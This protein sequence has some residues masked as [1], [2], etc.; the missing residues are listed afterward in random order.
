MTPRFREPY[1]LFRP[2]RLLKR[3][4]LPI[5]LT[6]TVSQTQI[7]PTG[8]GNV[9]GKVTDN[10]T[11][12]ALGD[13]SI[14]ISGG[15]QNATSGVDGL[16]TL[17]D[18]I[19]GIHTISATRSSYRDYSSSVT[20]TANTTVTHN[21]AMTPMEIPPPEPGKGHV[22][23]IVN[24][25]D[26][27]ALSGVACAIVEKGKGTITA[28]TDSM[29]KYTLRNVTPGVQRVNMTKTGYS[30]ANVDTT[31]VEGQTVTAETVTMRKEIASGTTLLCS[32]PRTKEDAAKW[33]NEPTVSDDGGLVA[34][35][36][37]QPL[38]ATH[39]TN[40]IHTYLFQTS[41][42]TVTMLDRA[43]D[44]LEGNDDCPGSFICGNGSRVAFASD[45]TN[46]LGQGM[47]ANGWGDIFLY[48]VSSGK[49]TRIS[50]DIENKKIGGD[51]TS[52]MPSMSRDG[53]YVAFSSDA[54]N[55]CMPGLYTNPG[56]PDTINVYRAAVGPDGTTSST[57]MIS[58]RL[59]GGECDLNDWGGVIP[60]RSMQ[61]YISSDGRFVVYTSNAQKGIWWAAQGHGPADDDKTL[62][63]F[64]AQRDTPGIGSDIFLCDT[65]KT[66]GT[67]TR[68]VSIDKNNKTQPNIVG[69]GLP[70][71]WPSVSDDGSLVAFECMDQGNTWIANSDNFFDV[72]VKNVNTGELK[73]ITTAN[74]GVRGD[75]NSSKI[76]RD[77]TLCVFDSQSTGFVEHD[78][79]N[80]LDIFVYN[81]TTGEYTRVNLGSNGQQAEDTVTGGGTGSE[82]PFLS[83]NNNFVVFESDAKNLASSPYF[84]TGATDVFL[85]KWQ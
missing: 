35:I 54:D 56:T 73:R 15:P 77:G 23:G 65:T 45:A 21:I 20:V 12:I 63:E 9:A 74:S 50:T 44:G 49:V 27:N 6:Q 38:L 8:T 71:M 31:V 69:G 67:W 32:I 84:T 18:V 14:T 26:G 24:D 3:Q 57:M 42:G 40:N 81:M 41:S 39:I 72:W 85:R 2:G 82:W 19:V 34:F 25:E 33:A 79:N 58:Q 29:G 78:T 11:G 61:P 17:E 7:T 10:S 48:D 83:G 80:S 36:A 76:S 37:N 5:L 43:P 68:L 28:Q 75:S 66:I 64:D 16:Y 22:T 47:D 59:R 46:L 51:G 30:N 60:I 13:A 1:A 4:S 52:M 55:L 62:T 70:C 53:T